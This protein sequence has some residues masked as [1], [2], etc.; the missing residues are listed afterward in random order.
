LEK[1]RE[2]VDF[3]VCSQ[4]VFLELFLRCENVENSDGLAPL[5]VAWR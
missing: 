1:E 2:Y 3:L 5:A 4:G